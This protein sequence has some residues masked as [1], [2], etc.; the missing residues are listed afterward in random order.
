MP[1]TTNLTGTTQLDNSII[2]LMDAQFIIAQEEM[3]DM[4]QLATIKLSAQAKSIEFPKYS[5]LA[6]A[7]TPLV[8]T[9]DVVSEAVSDSQIIVTPAEYGNVVTT[10]KLANLQTGGKADLVASRLVGMNAGR[11]KSKLALM[12]MDAS[13]NKLNVGGKAD[14][15]ILS[16]D[17]MTAT[18]LNRMYSYLSKKHVMPLL[19]G[20]YVAVLGTDVIHDLR[21]SVGAGSWV[22]INKYA[23]PETVLRNEVGMLAGFRI[24]ENNFVNVEADAGDALVDLYTSYFVGMNGL[25][26]GESMPVG[27]KLTGPFDKLG[28]FVSFG[29]HGVFKFAL[30]D[31]DA[32]AISKTASSIGVN[33]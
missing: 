33:A 13:S 16:T 25:L 4:S 2:E 20:T 32:V 15:S 12:A 19:D 27:M 8:E 10:T 6:L 5:Q 9:D 28:R 24:V 18:H 23:R 3:G 1:F 31:T 14:G 17:V 30:G 11:T 26:Y 29:W 22:D 7:T 21:N